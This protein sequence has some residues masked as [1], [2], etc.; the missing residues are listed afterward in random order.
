MLAVAA[1]LVLVFA[2]WAYLGANLG[3]LGKA[4]GTAPVSHGVFFGSV[5]GM[6]AVYGLY[7]SHWTLGQ[8]LPVAGVL[9]VV[10][11]VSGGRALSEV[12]ARRERGER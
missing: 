6:E 3:H 9:G 10:A 2:L 1:P 5:V 8:V 7:Y 12:Q 11:F 4:M